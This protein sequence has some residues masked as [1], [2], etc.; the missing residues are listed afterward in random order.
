[1]I[2]PFGD[3]NLLVVFGLAGVVVGGIFAMSITWNS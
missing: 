2:L 1:M 3:L